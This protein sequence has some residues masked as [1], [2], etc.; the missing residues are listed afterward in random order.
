MKVKKIQELK[1]YDI[2]KLQ[3]IFNLTEDKTREVLKILA[4]KNIV[5]KISKNL[6]EVELEELNN[7]E[8]CRIA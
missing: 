1:L 5:R 6:S 2:S 8:L 3:S 7:A 4:Y